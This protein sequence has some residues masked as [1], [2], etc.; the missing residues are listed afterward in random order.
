MSG[1][2][3]S[4]TVGPYFAYGLAA[5]Q[6]HYPG[7]QVADATIGPEGTAGRIRVLGNVYDGAGAAI[8]DALIE[9]WQAD[10]AGLYGAEGFKGFGRCGTGTHPDGCFGFETIK[11]GRDGAAAP[12]LTLAVFM[13]GLLSHV[14]TRAY[15]DDEAAANAADPVLAETPA[16]RRATLIAVRQK[17]AGLPTYRFD[18]HMQ[19]ERETVFFDV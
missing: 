1:Q 12:F 17:D 9:V 19:G 7:V 3:P 2:T 13:R 14:F 16:S 6:Y 10:A 4:Q 8:R 5:Q 15:F 18:I 11:P